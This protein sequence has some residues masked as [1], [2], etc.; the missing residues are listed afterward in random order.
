M[1]IFP[2]LKLMAKNIEFLKKINLS[3]VLMTREI[4]MLICMANNTMYKLSMG[5]STLMLMVKNTLSMKKILIHLQKMVPSR[6]M[7]TTIESMIMGGFLL[8]LMARS[9]PS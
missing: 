8:R 7:E 2:I 1:A 9:T 3:S 5:M 6:K 4:S